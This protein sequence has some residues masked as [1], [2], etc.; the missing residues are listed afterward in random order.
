[1]SKTIAPIGHAIRA[2]F[3]IGILPL[4]IGC[5]YLT[6]RN[7]KEAMKRQCDIPPFAS[8]KEY[9]GYPATTG[10]EREA[11]RISGKYKIPGR[12]VVEFESNLNSSYEWQPLPIPP[13]ILNKIRH[14]PEL[15]DLE[16]QNGFFRCRT[17]ENNVLHQTITSSCFE[18]IDYLMIQKDPPKWVWKAVPLK[19]VDYFPNLIISVYKSNSRTLTAGVASSY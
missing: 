17:S 16:A 19:T 8:L 1:M 3:I 18:P 13:E 11:L 10:L 15:V 2:S 5:Q 4:V 6:D 7:D 14:K 12:K 9:K